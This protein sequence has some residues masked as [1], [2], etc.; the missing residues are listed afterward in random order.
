MSE[1]GQKWAVIQSW[2]FAQ[3][4]TPTEKLILLELVDHAN[5]KEVEGV[6]S[7]F[8]KQGTTARR[9]GFSRSAVHRAIKNMEKL[10]LLSHIQRKWKGLQSSNRYTLNLDVIIQ[11]CCTVTHGRVAEGYTAVLQSDT[12]ETSSNKHQ[13]ETSSTGEP[14]QENSD[15]KV[16]EVLQGFTTP[17]KEDIIKNA[18]RKN[19]TLTPGGCAYLW[20]GFRH[21]AGASG[22][23]G[24]LLA[25]EK[26]ML[27]RVR[28]RIGDQKYIDSLWA[29]MES[30]V[31]YT[32][33]AAEKGGA[34]T[35]P[36][37]P[38]VWFFTKFCN[39]AVGFLGEDIKKVPESFV[40]VIAN[41]EKPLTKPSE[42]KENVKVGMTYEEILE[43]NRE[44]ED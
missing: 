34:Y 3:R 40:Q 18:K 35:L 24:E 13:I 19:G 26:N 21:A 23:Q 33:Y 12:L 39:E 28:K 11:P 5:D 37:E 42:T 17:E 38:K 36:Q 14:G 8:P 4:I 22:F 10:G 2:A 41:P 32:K 31:P 43:I 9:T 16:K 1:K 30:W 7:C 25:K 6:F 15:M 29:V 44:F 20:R 27:S